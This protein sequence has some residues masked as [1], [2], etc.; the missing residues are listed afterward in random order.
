[1]VTLANV[2]GKDLVPGLGERLNRQLLSRQVDL[3]E[4]EF[5]DKRDRADIKQEGINLAF[6]VFD[7]GGEFNRR[8]GLELLATIDPQAATALNNIVKSNNEADIAETARTADRAFKAS[9]HLRKI[10]GV[11]PLDEVAKKRA[12][13]VELINQ[14]I[15]DDQPHDKLDKIANA[16]TLE[17]MNLHIT[18]MGAIA[19]VGSEIAKERV[20]ELKAA[21]TAILEALKPPTTRTITRGDKTVA[22]QFN[23]D[24]QKFEDV[25]E[26]P[27]F[28]EKEEK[29]PLTDIGKAR[30][31]LKDKKITQKDF[32][33]IA[34]TPNKFQSTMGK[35][36]ADLQIAKAQFGKTSPE[37]KAIVAA[38]NKTKKGATATVKPGVFKLP[39]DSLINHSQLLS[40]YRLENNLLEPLQLRILEATNPQMAVKER[41]KILDALPFKEWAKENFGVDV[42]GGFVP[43]EKPA[44]ALPLPADKSSLVIGQTYQTAR[45]AA[46]WDGEMFE[47]VGE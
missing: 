2:T 41:Q 23:R 14:R 8:R 43:E 9:E 10:K 5:L 1:M 11:N 15:I 3:K 22:Q 27:R 6:E 39:D 19:N 29:P 30:K 34:A 46:V 24:T 32:D 44:E 26:G 18:K 12:A 16:N 25:A 31:D 35:L 20:A 36:I 37:A 45:G 13:A 17:E 4:Q 40:Q 47:S 42:R 28:Q 7:R 38:I 33:T 21:E